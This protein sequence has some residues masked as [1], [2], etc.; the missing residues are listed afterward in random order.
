MPNEIAANAEMQTETPTI[1]S[2]LRTRGNVSDIT[3]LLAEEGNAQAAE[4]DK[5]RTD[6]DAELGAAPERIEEA[7]DPDL[8]EPESEPAA[9]D[10]S[11][12]E[13][14]PEPQ[15]KIESFK[16]L[17]EATGLELS[18]LYDLTIAFGDGENL[19]PMKLGAIK[20]AF[21]KGLEV[22]SKTETLVADK[23][24]FENMQI[25]ANR[26]IEETISNL[27]LTP[28]QVAAQAHRVGEVKLQEQQLLFQVVP[29]LAKNAEL[30]QQTHQEIVDLVKP[31]GISALE[32][33]NLADHRFYKFAMDTVQDRKLIAEARADGKR[34]R[35]IGT[36]ERIQRKFNG[37]G[38]GDQTKTDGLIAKAK[39]SRIGK[40]QVN[41]ISALLG[42]SV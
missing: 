29:E 14:K 15:A 24:E 38:K 25:V 26:A 4:I 30:R 8:S 7:P 16:D 35:K 21:Q 33:D 2:G 22:D 31:Y 39:S 13:A 6:G 36:G 17:A 34:V 11:E 28:Q 1:E 27:Q 3:A 5:R 41:A 12:P 20:D 32:I 40:D 42:E 10:D 37:K 19:E 9:H 18:A 23:K